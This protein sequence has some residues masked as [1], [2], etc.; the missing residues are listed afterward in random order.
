[1]FRNIFKRGESPDTN[2]KINTTERTKL[3]L[4]QAENFEIALMAMDYVLDDRA[5][6][7][8]KL[9]TEN[10]E[11]RDKNDETINVL[12]KGVIEFL[13]AT[14]SFETKEMKI[15]SETLA[16]AEQLSLKSKAKAEKENIKS[17]SYYPPGTVY[18]VT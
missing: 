3:I 7:G 11:H 12:A 9:L 1:M 4:K 15:A 14:L 2:N 17:S 13:A 10:S 8:L 18:A 16:K 6:E 5:Q